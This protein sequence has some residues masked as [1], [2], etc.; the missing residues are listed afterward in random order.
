[1]SAAL[2]S[3]PSVLEL[4]EAGAVKPEAVTSLAETYLAAPGLRTYTLVL[5]LVVDVAAAIQA[6]PL[7]RAMMRSS[8]AS[9]RAK[10]ATVA[11]AIMLARPQRI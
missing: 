1:M 8:L 2:S 10:R 7:A 3:T 6:Y 5:G 11:T 4:L 9:S